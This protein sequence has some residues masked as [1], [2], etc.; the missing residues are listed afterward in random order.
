MVATKV[1]YAGGTTV[2]PD[3]H[4]TGDHRESVE[5]TYD[6]TRTS[7]ARLLD[8]FW[9][10]HPAVG[11]EGPRRTS[12]AALVAG[13][14][15]RRLAVA[16][17]RRVACAAGEAVNTRVEPVGRF[18][19]AE[20]SNQKANLQRRAPELV[21]ELAARFGG[22]DAFLASTAAAKLNA[23]AGGFAGE[24]ALDDA[25]RE[26]GLPASELKARIRR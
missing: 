6:P 21:E 17:R 13:E 20:S 24:E 4:H 11:G 26:L 5:V 23:Y 12:E 14:E 10:A 8:V 9:A 1:G 22:R 3:Y 18:W 7:Y 25:A 16:S 2:D 15:Q 19:V